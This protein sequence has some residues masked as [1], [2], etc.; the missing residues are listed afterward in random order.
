MP[1]DIGTAVREVCLWLPE[2][3]EFLSH[4][5]PNFRV[6]GK[7]FAAY[8]VNHHGDGRIALWL[9]SPAG[10]QALY[11]KEE[12]KHFFVPPYVGPRGWLGVNLDKGISWKRVAK[13]VREA[14]EKVAPRALSA[15]LGATIDIKPPTAKL[16]PED[17]DP[18][19]SKRART[20]LD[21]LRGMCLELQGT[22][23]SSAFGVP[24]WRVGK[25]TF[26]CAGH[27][28]ERLTLLF[29]VGVEQQSLYM[30][31]KRYSIP[32]YMGHNGWISIDVTKDANWDEI[33]GL[34]LNSY[35]HFAP[36]RLAAALD[37][38]PSLETAAPKRKSGTRSPRGT[39]GARGKTVNRKTRR[40]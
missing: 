40:S 33:R 19:Q 38:H 11:T 13:L 17:I 29:W 24:V 4:G 28:R 5:S 30:S 10:A 25:K 20:L 36:K 21:K 27:G 26:V 14:Y 2:A 6:R 1:K 39:R 7:T 23:E 8:C 32:P 12:P 37:A 34:M 15:T 31:D 18:L 35:R 3:E 16:K 22:N 9:S